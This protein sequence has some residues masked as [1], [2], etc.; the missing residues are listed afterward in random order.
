MTEEETTET[1]I[2]EKNMRI[3]VRKNYKGETAVEY[4]VRA[5]TPEELKILLVEIKKI[6]AEK[7]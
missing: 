3:T 5:D 7:L 6:I 2:R 4:T 1:L